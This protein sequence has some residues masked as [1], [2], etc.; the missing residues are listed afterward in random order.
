MNLLQE[1]RREGTIG[2]EGPIRGGKW[3]LAN[4]PPE[5]ATFSQKTG[6]ASQDPEQEPPIS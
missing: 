1:M 4:A 5:A 6:A 3:V 2:H